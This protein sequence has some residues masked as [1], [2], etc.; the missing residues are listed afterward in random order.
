MTD[1]ATRRG[2]VALDEPTLRDWA[3][4]LGRAAGRGRVFVALYGELGAG[5]STLVRAAC[6]GLGVEGAVP[7]PTY[8]LVNVHR[9]TT[10]SV[11]H[12]DLY[13]LDPPVG[14]RVLD[15][16]GWPDLLAAEGAVFVE[17]ADRAADHLPRDRWDVTL[18]RLDDPSLRE[19]S[20]EVVGDAPAPPAPPDAGEC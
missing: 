9:G 14:A 15:D 11:L 10:G 19:V 17:W 7:S 18:R 20:V 2:S 13:R 6:R 1:A 16:A 4:E 5:K 3:A 12:A 8:T